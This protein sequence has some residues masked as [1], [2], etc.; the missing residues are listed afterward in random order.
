MEVI[1]MSYSI[2]LLEVVAAMRSVLAVAKTLQD[3]FP[4]AK[5][6]EITIALKGTMSLKLARLQAKIMSLTPAQR[7]SMY[8]LT[9]AEQVL[10]DVQAI[11]GKA[12]E[13]TAEEIEDGLAAQA[14]KT[15][16]AV[17]TREATKAKKATVTAKGKTKDMFADA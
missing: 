7:A 13:R 6:E 1:P 12:R 17:A 10:P 5:P 8:A 4:A 9:N 11:L 3:K 16:K 15:A 2:E 14:T